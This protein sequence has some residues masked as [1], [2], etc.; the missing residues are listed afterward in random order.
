M[1]KTK[2]TE[3]TELEKE[4]FVRRITE[5][6]VAFRIGRSVPYVSARITGKGEWKLTETYTILT[7]LLNKD[8]Y[9]FAKVFPPEE[10]GLRHYNAKRRA[11]K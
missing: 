2:P 4:L 7:E 6:E 3:R 10:V 5:E 11:T 9:E 8:P 1:A